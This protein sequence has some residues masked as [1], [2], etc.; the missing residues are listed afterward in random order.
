MLS[1]TSI[2]IAVL[3]AM[4]LSV[5]SSY[6]LRAQPKAIDQSKVSITLERSA[7]FGPCPVYR[8]TINGDGR[9]VFTT[10]T[11]PVDKIDE[12]HRRFA[13]SDGVLLPGTHE[14]RISPA[15]VASLIKKFQAAQFWKLR[16]SYR[17]PVTDS[18]SYVMT[19]DTGRTRK[20][21]TD[22]VGSEIGMPCGV[23]ELEEAIDQVAGTDRWVRGTAGLLT[24]LE[25]TGFNFQSTEAVE[26]ATSAAFGTGSE[27]TAIGLIKRGA[28][29]DRN[30][31]L[32]GS[33]SA[34]QI[35]PPRSAGVIITDSALRR[36][37]AELFRLMAAGGWLNKLGKADT[38]QAFAQYAAGCSPQLVDAAADAGIDV[39][40][41]AQIDANNHSESP[42]GKTALAEL[43]SSYACDQHEGDRLK[44]AERLIAHGANP[45]SRDS[46]GRTPLYGIENLALLNFLLAHGADATAKD[47]DGQSM[48]FGSWTDTI[49]LRLLEA[50][51]SP[52]GHYDVDVVRTLAQQAKY[53]KMPLVAKWLAAHPAAYS[54]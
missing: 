11:E 38:A 30:T 44:T 31:V 35:M 20:T 41:S 34:S 27:E 10:A 50:G 26:L 9:V 53:R 45:N 29:L 51:A 23:T 52:A 15:A 8:V 39:D 17:A 18:P 42:Q 40:F 36:G 2:R 12:L 24:W 43:S 13:L 46:A 48:I 37:H 32:S 54:R 47:K 7:C 19:F 21:V 3:L 49:V 4:S 6:A 16:A 33:W 5:T 1:K 14:D 28:P 25:R 22:Y